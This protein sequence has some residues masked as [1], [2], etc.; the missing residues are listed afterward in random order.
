MNI[1]DT[2]ASSF[3]WVLLNRFHL[4]T[5]TESSHRNV[6]LYIKYRTGDNV[7]IYNSCIHIPV[8]TSL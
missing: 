5:E 8:N 2:E 3:H 4:K 6:M 7:Q 1:P